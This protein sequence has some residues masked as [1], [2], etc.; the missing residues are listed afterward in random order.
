MTHS[1][2]LMMQKPCWL[3]RYFRSC[4]FAGML[5]LMCLFISGCSRP[6]TFRVVDVRTGKPVE[7][8]VALATWGGSRGLPGLTYRYTAKALEA[9]SDK[10]GYFT[11]PGQLGRTAFNPPLLQVYK[12]GYVG[13]NSRW[14]FIPWDK[15]GKK[16]HTAR[17][18]KRENFFW[19]RQ[20]IYLHP[21]KDD[22]EYNHYTH[23][24]FVSPGGDTYRGGIK[25]S[26]Y[27]KVIDYDG[28]LGTQENNKWYY[29]RKQHE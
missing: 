9:V 10:D 13:W 6:V 17:T 19:E 20:I 24:S 26:K 28:D 27:R 21:W 1:V 8:A 16:A 3:S 11:I 12:P 5:L 2:F 15:N 23:W 25:E 22:A 7:G 14:I 18:K 4:A 29:E